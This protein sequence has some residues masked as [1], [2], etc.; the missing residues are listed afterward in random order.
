MNN[1]PGADITEA[2]SALINTDE[3]IV[4]ALANAAA[5]L[6]ERLDRINWTG[7][8]LVD[9][10]RLV[11]GPFCGKPACTAIP[12]GKGVC[13]TA[14]AEGTTLRVDDVDLF[15]GHIACDEASRSEIVVPIVTSS[16]GLIGVLDI[17]APIP[18][19]FTR[20]D[21]RSIEGFVGVLVE[22]LDLILAVNGG[23]LFA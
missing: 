11:L 22:K 12:I 8:Y 7:F 13:G 18:A 10:G 14:A 20:D 15:P 21:Q 1:K 3:P 2:L 19:R 5:L 6:Y 16:H 4:T 17:D 23:K 9:G